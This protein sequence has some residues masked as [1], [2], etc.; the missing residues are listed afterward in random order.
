MALKE[1]TTLK[2]NPVG[3]SSIQMGKKHGGSALK[4]IFWC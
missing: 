2:E 3:Q 1:H 4:D